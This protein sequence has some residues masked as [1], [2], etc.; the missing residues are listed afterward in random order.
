MNKNEEQ[1]DK[2]KI[3]FI[4]ATESQQ[5][6]IKSILSEREYQDAK[7][8]NT[9][10]SGRPSDMQGALDRTID[11]F[12]LY[13]QHQVNELVSECGTTDDPSKKIEIMRKIA[14]LAMAC[15]ERHGMPKRLQFEI[16]NQKGSLFNTGE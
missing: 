1:N 4:D 5:K 11:E 15:G 14:G 9:K 2:A 7:W 13:I 6:V 10:S 12:A 3:T 8:G 16:D